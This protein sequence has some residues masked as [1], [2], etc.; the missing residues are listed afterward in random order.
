MIQE[1]TA[2]AVIY[3]DRA[4]QREFLIVQS[5]KNHRWGF[6]K[7][8]LA[9]GETPQQATKREIKEETGLTPAFDFSFSAK[10]QYRAFSKKMKQV[11]YYLAQAGPSQA[12]VIE[13]SEIEASRWVTLE[14][15]PTYLTVHGKMGVLKKAQAFLQRKKAV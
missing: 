6:S 1:F 15:A 10:T 7:G 13:P 8:H 14:Q 9:P 2:G 4:G 5:I 3:R 12:V 11:T